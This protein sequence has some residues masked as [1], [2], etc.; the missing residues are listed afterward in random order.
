MTYKSGVKESEGVFR[1][2]RPDGHWATWHRD[3]SKAGEADFRDG[4]PVGAF[5]TWHA[6][7]QK[8]AD[9]RFAN[10]G[11]KGEFTLWDR[12]GRRRMLVRF[13]K[14]QVTH[15]QAWDERGREVTDPEQFEQQRGYLDGEPNTL[16]TLLILMAGGAR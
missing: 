14:G 3:G 11:A 4:R 6:N 7:G 15:T 12:A 1:D 8:S 9:G 2:G 10:G 13:T 16:L 5:T